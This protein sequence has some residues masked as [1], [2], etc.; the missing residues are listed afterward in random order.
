MNINDNL[1]LIRK[2]NDYYSGHALKFFRR[3]ILGGVFS[4]VFLILMLAACSTGNTAPKASITPTVP[5]HPT[6]TTLPSGT[7]L[8]QSDWSHGLDNWQGSTGWKVTHGMLQS[9]LRDGDVLT[10]PYTPMVPNYTLEVRFQIVSVPKN[11]GNFVI[12]ADKVPGKDGYT[13]GIMNLLGPGPRSQFANP[14]VE[15]YLDPIDAMESSPP[16]SDYEPGSGVHTY[17]IEVQ[18]PLV[19]FF[20]DDLRRSSVTSSQTD[21][22]SNGPIHLRADQAIVNVFSVRITVL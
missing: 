13:A 4:V 3:Q 19:Q 6:P 14:Q 20:I 21:F 15:V 1:I 16:V 18:G 17:R 22:L 2:R 9:D 11:G 5:V 12:L 10:S 8:Y 7:L